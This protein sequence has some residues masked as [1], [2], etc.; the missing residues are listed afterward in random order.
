[1]GKRG[2]RKNRRKDSGEEITITESKEFQS[3]GIC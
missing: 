1:M 3:E 2:K